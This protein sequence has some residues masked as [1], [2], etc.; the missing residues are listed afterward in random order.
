MVR[1]NILMTIF[2]LTL[3][4]RKLFAKNLILSSSSVNKKSRH[5]YFIDFQNSDIDF[6]NFNIGLSNCET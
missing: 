3:A 6:L 2:D 4:N 1:E 5:N